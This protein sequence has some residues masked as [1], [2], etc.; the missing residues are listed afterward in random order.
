MRIWIVLLAL[1]AVSAPAPLF[2]QDAQAERQKN[3]HQ[4]RGPDA[5]GVAH[6]DPPTEWSESKN[7]RW[8]VEIPGEGSSTPIV[9]G[10]KIFLL[11]AIE[12]ERVG[13]N[14]QLPADQPERQFGIVF[15][16]RIHEFVMLCLDRTTGKTLWRQ[17]ATEQV[18]H[19]GTHPDNDFASAS[20]ITDGQRLY[21]SFGSR[22][23]YC[24]DLNGRKSVV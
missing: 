22:G 4:W 20:P 8:K 5:D 3:W 1:L 10:D 9:W 16:H 23:V 14:V 17:V 7:V 19:E 12:I 21:V 11:T 13:E 24:Y 18:P 15:P 2:A 6:G